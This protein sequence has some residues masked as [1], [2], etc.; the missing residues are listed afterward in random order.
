MNG[1]IGI[2]AS[3]GW[4]ALQAPGIARADHDHAFMM[5]EHAREASSELSAGVALEAASY[6]NGT[7]VG[8]YQGIMPSLGWQR[9][10]F[11][12]MATIGMYHAEENGL[13]V[14][15]FGDAMATA[16]ATVWGH[17]GVDHS[18]QTGVALHVM[19]PT[20]SELQSLGMGHVMLMPSAWGAWQQSRLTVTASAGYSRAAISINA[21]HDHG[22]PV[23]DPMNLQELTWSAG[24]DLAVGAGIHV[25]GHTLGG[26]P[27]GNGRT[28]VIGG[29]RVGWGTTRISTGLELQLGLAGDPFSVRGVVDTA[30]RF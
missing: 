4:L 24:A 20:G 5:S 25:G 23:V 7:F 16:H 21:M 15:G 13:S 10:R 6:D 30:L 14:Y 3:A 11:G 29:G 9:G 28:R 22:G 18:V 12:A 2:A 1:R 19:V 27:I 8:S 17:D 26:I